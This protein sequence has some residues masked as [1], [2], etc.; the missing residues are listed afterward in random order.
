MFF[1]INKFIFKN[2]I[3]SKKEINQFVNNILGDFNSI[4]AKN[5]NLEYQEDII[6]L[7][8]VFLYS[9]SI[10]MVYDIELTDQKVV[11]ND[12]CFRNFIIERKGK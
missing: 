12:I 6:R 2:N 11:N 1:W 7:I 5:V 4:E 10:G 8:L 9:K 3:Y